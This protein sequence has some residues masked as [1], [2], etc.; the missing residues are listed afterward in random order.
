MILLEEVLFPLWEQM[1]R[2]TRY[3]SSVRDRLGNL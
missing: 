3:I 1:N 2:N